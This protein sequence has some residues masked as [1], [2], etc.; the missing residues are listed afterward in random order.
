[1][2]TAQIKR[3]QQATA[4]REEELA[5]GHAEMRHAGYVTV[6]G[7][8]AEELERSNSEVEHAGQ[9]ARLEFQ[10]LHGEQD[11]GFTFTL[12]LCQGLR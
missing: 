12:P 1:M 3:R 6:S 10:R 4:R 7:G 8:S 2:T 11:A 5:D 9:L